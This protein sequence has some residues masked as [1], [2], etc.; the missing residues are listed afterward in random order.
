MPRLSRPIPG[1][2]AAAPPVG[3]VAASKGAGAYN[4]DSESVWQNGISYDVES[5]VVPGTP[6][7]ICSPAAFGEALEPS[8]SEWL[9]YVVFADW[10]CSTFGTPNQEELNRAYE[11]ARRR[12]NATW[13]FQ[14]ERELWEGALAQAESYPNRWLADTANVDVLTDAG[15]VAPLNALACLTQYLAEVSGGQQGMIHATPQLVTHWISENV[16]YRQGPVLYT[17]ARD[18]IVVPGAGYTGSNPSQDVPTDNNV[19]A[20][21]TDIVEVRDGAVDPG[22]I[23]GNAVIPWVNPNNRTVI[24]AQ[25]RALASWEGCRLGGAQV[26]ISVCNVGTS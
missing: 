25:K 6:L 18:D 16:V 3:L 5:C 19:W 14:V 17:V 22:G 2:R 23:G 20:Y 10:A 9:P 1:R 7:D 26:E 13:G 8:S 24:R 21:A 12:L 15:A 4:P 11:A